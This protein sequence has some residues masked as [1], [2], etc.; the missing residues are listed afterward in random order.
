MSTMP[1]PMTLPDG[2]SS[3]VAAKSTGPRWAL[4][5]TGFVIYFV[6]G[7]F[8]AMAIGPLA[9]GFTF[10]VR[11][12]FALV[13]AVIAAVRGATVAA[14][15]KPDGIY[16]RNRW[17]QQTI[18]WS[19]VRSVDESASI[20]Y[21]VVLSIRTLYWMF[22]PAHHHYGEHVE[23]GSSLL[24]VHREG[25][26]LGIPLYATLGHPM[27][28]HQEPF[29]AALTAADH[30]VHALGAQASTDPPPPTPWAPAQPR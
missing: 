3:G 2:D 15:V 20:G 6:L 13:P 16:V 28:P 10:P 21:T 26:R 27:G 14:V 7:V 11:L 4:A 12:A 24:T 17:R 25:H 19:E 23:F 29:R 8:V 5:A 18:P 22:G 1:F 30:P 9:G